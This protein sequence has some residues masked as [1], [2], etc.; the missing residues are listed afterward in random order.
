MSFILFLLLAG[1][2]VWVFLKSFVPIAL[3]LLIAALIQLTT[4][5]PWQ[6]GG[7]WYGLIWIAWWVTLLALLFYLTKT[8]LAA[9]VMFAIAAAVI[10]LSGIGAAVSG[11]NDAAVPVQL[12][13]S[14][15]NPETGEAESQYYATNQDEGNEVKASKPV[16]GKAATTNHVINPTLT[17]AADTNL[18]EC[19]AKSG[20]RGERAKEAFKAVGLDTNS[21]QKQ[22]VYVVVMNSPDTSA[23]SARNMVKSYTG[24]RADVLYFNDAA[25]VNSYTDANGTL[26][27]FHDARSQVRPLVVQAAH[28][29]EADKKAKQV[30]GYTSRIV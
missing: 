15:T 29:A 12:T 9:L 23:A 22:Y 20:Q 10:I 21:N 26:K 3:M 19:I 11:S 28:K 27:W 4:Y 13:V 5:L 1:L 7:F 16:S 14:A 18:R 2:A 30:Q 25:V 6:I 24:D 8:L 17:C